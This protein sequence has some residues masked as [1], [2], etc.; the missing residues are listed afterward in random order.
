VRSRFGT[1]DAKHESKLRVLRREI[2]V[3]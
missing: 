3:A 1:I 2:E